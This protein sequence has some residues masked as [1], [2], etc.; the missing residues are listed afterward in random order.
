MA[1]MSGISALRAQR[2]EEVSLFL[3]ST[4]CTRKTEMPEIRADRWLL[5]VALLRS[6]ERTSRHLARL[7]ERLPTERRRHVIADDCA[8]RPG[9]RRLT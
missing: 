6:P 7:L 9:A 1:G 2:V 8:R 3:T 4:P 5:I